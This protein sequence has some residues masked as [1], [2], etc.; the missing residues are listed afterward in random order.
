MY[1]AET[2]KNLSDKKEG[3]DVD[4][5]SEEESNAFSGTTKL[6]VIIMP[7]CAAAMV[8]IVI[9]VAALIHLR[10]KGRGRHEKDVSNMTET[11]SVISR[12]P[13]LIT[14]DSKCYQDEG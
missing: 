6:I 14:F 10:R 1:I 13:S 4:K 9:S 12:N 3:P 5:S 7:P 11:T 8:I 2:F